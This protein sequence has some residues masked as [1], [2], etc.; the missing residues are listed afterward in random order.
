MNYQ[1]KKTDKLIK[2]PHPIAPS[3]AKVRGNKKGNNM[4]ASI[5]IIT[6][7]SIAVSII[8]GIFYSVSKI[9]KIDNFLYKSN[10]GLLISS[11]IYLSL[12]L[13]GVSSIISLIEVITSALV[14]TLIL[15]GFTQIKKINQEKL[16]LV[17]KYSQLHE[18]IPLLTANNRYHISKIKGVIL[19]EPSQEKYLFKQKIRNL[20][21]IKN[22]ETILKKQKIK[23][24]LICS[25]YDNN[26][27]VFNLIN[28]CIKNEINYTFLYTEQNFYKIQESKNLTAVPKKYYILKSNN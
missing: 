28:Y 16:I 21:S 20:G 22:F 3:F 26:L 12:E 19:Y 23:N 18:N 8:L 25:N 4:T 17:T 11:I 5:A 1:I 13:S 2:A 9:S 6:K 10:L 27:D 7:L 15:L 24:I 14:A